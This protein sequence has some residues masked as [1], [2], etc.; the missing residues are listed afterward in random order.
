MTIPITVTGSVV[1]S[2]SL[3][4]TGSISNV[5]ASYVAGGDVDGAVANAT[6][7]VSA[8]YAL[9]SDAQVSAS[10]AT[11][12]SYA[13]TSENQ[14]SSSHALQ[15]DNAATADSAVSSSH[16]LL[17]DEVEFNNV[18]NKP[19]LVS[20]SA[21]IIDVLDTEAVVSGGADASLGALSASAGHFAGDITVEGT[22]SFGV[23]QTVYV[24][25]S[26]I[27]ASGS[28]KF[29]DTSDDVHQRTGSLI[30]TD[31]ITGDGSLIT[32]IV[33]A[34]HSAQA[35]N[36]ATADLATSATS[37]TS[38]SHATQTDSASYAPTNESASTGSFTGS[39]LGGI[40][41]T[42]NSTM[43]SSQFAHERVDLG[44]KSADFTVSFDVGNVQRFEATADVEFAIENLNGIGLVECENSGAFDVTLPSALWSTGSTQTTGSKA[45][46]S[47]DVFTFY[48][49]GTNLI[50]SVMAL[51]AQ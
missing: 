7:A 12:A 1:V 6:T 32:G 13:E 25:S 20:S 23:F 49:A 36:A 44:A 46:G 5:T 37:A 28:T 24:T 4:S 34:S 38:A 19:T 2:G 21:Q 41:L 22:G 47:I 3:T 27:E 16:S 11:T 18:L 45:T 43:S 8:S 33:S 14:V 42:D 31:G 48:Q 39:F 40:D 35:D 26:I 15:A 30:V 29:G 50:G 17:S 10:F 9:T 51:D